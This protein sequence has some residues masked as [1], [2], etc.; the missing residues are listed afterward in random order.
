VPEKFGEEMPNR[1]ATV[2]KELCWMALGTTP[3]GVLTDI[4]HTH[5]YNM[6]FPEE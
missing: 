1:W 6:V 5:I 3:S 2:L 4:T